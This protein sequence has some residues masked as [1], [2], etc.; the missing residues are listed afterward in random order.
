MPADPK[1]LGRVRDPD[2]LGV[3]AGRPCQ[4]TGL[5]AGVCPRV[6]SHHLMKH[7]RND[8]SGNLFRII[9]PLHREF[10]GGTR[11][12]AVAALIRAFMSREQEEYLVGELGRA[13][14]DKTYP[15]VSV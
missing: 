3:F 2:L 9:E 14:L 8:V 5:V 1:P 6:E 13:W 4:V 11:R 7:P 12:L 15:D 10:E